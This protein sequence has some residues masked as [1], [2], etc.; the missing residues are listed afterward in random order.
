MILI[1]ISAMAVWTVIILYL[2][3]LDKKIREFEKCL[4]VSWKKE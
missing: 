1:F 4:E 3:H 2:L